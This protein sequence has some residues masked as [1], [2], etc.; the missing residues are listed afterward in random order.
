M[1]QGIFRMP[2]DDK[3]VLPS[4]LP[5]YK[6]DTNKVCYAL[7]EQEPSS[8]QILFKTTRESLNQ[9]GETVSYY[10]SAYSISAD[11]GDGHRC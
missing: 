2:D 1:K 11:T 3:T 7:V 6:D 4:S 10:S 8:L 5:F 9:V